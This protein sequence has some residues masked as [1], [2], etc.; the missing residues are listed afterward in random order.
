MTQPR[1]L[2]LIPLL[3]ACSAERPTPPA[4]EAP[5]RLGA[6]P[7]VALAPE[8]A[9]A[10]AL[11]GEE[12]TIGT[13]PVACPSLVLEGG[14]QTAV[15]APGEVEVLSLR[16]RNACTAGEDLVISGLSLSEP[17]DGFEVL[18]DLEELVLAPGSSTSLEVRFAPELAG[19]YVADLTLS[20][21]DLT[22][23]EATA[24]LTGLT[25][26]RTARSGSAPTASTGGDQTVLTG[27]TVALDGSSSS[28]PEGDALTYSWTFKS[29]PTGSALTNAD[30]SGSSSATASFV[31]D[32]TGS[33]R[34]RFVVSD[35]TSHDKDFDWIW[36]TSSSNS[37]P[38][39]DAGAFTYATTGSAV[40][41][42]GSGSSDPDGD[43]L[44]W[45]WSFKSVPAGSAL[46]NADLT[47][48]ATATPSFTP[49]V[50][51]DYRMRLVVSDGAYWDKDFEW[52]RSSAPNTAPTAEAGAYTK[53]ATGDSH[54]LDGSAS[55]DPDGDALTYE[56]SWRSLPAG[57]ALTNADIVDSTTATPSF[58]S[59]VDGTYRLRL[60]VYDAVAWGKDFV[61]VTTT[62][63]SS[64]GD[65]ATASGE[66]GTHAPDFLIAQEVTL[67]SD[68]TLSAL[69]IGIASGSGNAVLALY[70]DSGG[71]PG[72]LLAQTASE[73]V[74]AGSNEL[75]LS[76]ADV[77]L[78]AGTYWIAKV[79]DDVAYVTESSTGGTSNT[80]TWGASSFSSSLPDPYG[81][82]E[83]MNEHVLAL[84]LVGY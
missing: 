79:H 61:N 41:L 49:D 70:E 15:A 17:A 52:V 80:S 84:W 50:D 33:Y 46:T 77:S 37:A 74:S 21:N 6:E 62:T 43:T 29:V 4:D 14:E 38:T 66:T 58:T 11:A 81:L 20:S 82:T 69:G 76:G 67:S 19:L 2:V 65:G 59:D 18:S 44:S 75:D 36:V 35:G 51:G 39:A 8:L 63:P 73:A 53:G 57:S 23:P 71:A 25:G 26:D 56:W 64:H 7:D 45:S 9:E 42:D 40:T 48:A 30:L 31:P 78:T 22:Q 55:S 5:A 28:D 10:L 34:I 1:A 83:T 3:V 24:T 47:D 60:V 68:I 12:P 27:S 54:S 16:L 72:A 32:V 13:S